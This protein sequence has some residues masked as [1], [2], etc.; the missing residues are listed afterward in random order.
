VH[1]LC[2][3]SAILVA[4]LFSLH[5]GMQ[6]AAAQSGLSSAVPASGNTITLAV[7]PNPAIAGSKSASVKVKGSGGGGSH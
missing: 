7:A 4:G 1:S 3:I 6:L 2:L 5:G